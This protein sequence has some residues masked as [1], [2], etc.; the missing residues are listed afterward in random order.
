MNHV[1][2]VGHVKESPKVI[3][4][5]H[6][7]Y[8]ASFAMEAQS[9]F[10]N[11]EGS[12]IEYLFDIILWQGCYKSFEDTLRPGDLVACKGRLERHDDKLFIVAESCEVL[13]PK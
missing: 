10:R 13:R 4:T 11:A 3:D 12:Y 1:H 9:N 5:S 6:A 7:K 8:Y 2:I